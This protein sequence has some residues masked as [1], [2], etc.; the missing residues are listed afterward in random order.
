MSVR[1]RHPDYPI[2]CN[3]LVEIPTIPLHRGSVCPTCS[4]LHNPVVHQYKT[5]HLRLQDGHAIVTE[6]VW[7]TIRKNVPGAAGLVAE[8]SVNNPPPMLVGA[9]AS[10]QEEIITEHGRLWVP[11]RTVQQSEKAAQAPLMPLLEGIA[12]KHDRRFTA[13]LAEKRTIFSLGKG[14]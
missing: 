4:R 7:D 5:I 6:G 11:G 13:K 8:N 9:V 10:P 14:K 1:L 3:F 2:N 12:E